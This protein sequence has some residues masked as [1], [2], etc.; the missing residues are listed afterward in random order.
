M[1]KQETVI[2][3]NLAPLEKLR[4][5]LAKVLVAKVGVRANTGPHTLAANQSKRGKKAKPVGLGNI[6]NVDLAII[7]IWGSVTKNIPARDFLGMPMIVKKDELM[8]FLKSDMIRKMI[9]EGKIAEI[10]KLLG[11]K[12]ETIVAEAFA[13]GGFGK[14]PKLK[15]ATVRA[16]GSSAILIATSQLRRSVSSWVGAK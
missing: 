16:K 2:S 8:K 4:G 9:A 3:I 15:A 10:Y 12:G 5:D 1:S 14:W 13:T 7:H 11:I 6:T